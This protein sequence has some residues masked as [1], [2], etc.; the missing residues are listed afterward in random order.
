MNDEL[1]EMI[2]KQASASQLQAAARKSAGL[3]LMREVG[4]GMARSG[5][6]TPD[7]VL[8]VTKV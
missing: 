3:T 8:R 2:L 7:E 6:T 4:F 5:I 1:R